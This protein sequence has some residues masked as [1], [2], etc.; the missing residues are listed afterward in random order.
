MRTN[1]P[2]SLLA[3]LRLSVAFD[4]PDPLASPKSMLSRAKRQIAELDVHIKKFMEDKPWSAVVEKDA[5][6]ITNLHKIK[7]T[8]RLSDD[9]AHIVFESANNL[10]AALDQLGFAVAQLNGHREPKSC[11]FPAGPTETDM[12]NNAKGGCKDLPSEIISLF[13]SFKNYKGGNNALWALNE[14]ANTPKHKL[15]YPVALG[16]FGINDMSFHVE[17]MSAG[18]GV[19]KSIAVPGPKW[20]SEKH[21]IILVRDAGA[22]TNF[23]YNANV[24]FTVALD[25]VDDVIRG[26]H[27]VT[28]LT[29]MASQVQNVLD[30][31]E[32]MC[33]CIGLIK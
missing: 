33:R 4:M 11:K 7:F 13:E 25:N 5:D 21:E 29:V 12:R 24:A 26:Q 30:L 14:L 22:G 3:A 8:A 18:G 28:V 32:T 9:L 17:R 31:T 15:L 10:R 20:D 19:A 27:P 6:G 1:A 2:I 23:S 16:G